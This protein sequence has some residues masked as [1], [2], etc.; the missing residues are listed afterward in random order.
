MQYIGPQTCNH[1]Q[2]RGGSRS[3]RLRVHR[4]RRA[5]RVRSMREPHTLRRAHR[6]RY[7]L[8]ETS[9]RSRPVASILEITVCHVRQPWLSTS[10]NNNNDDDA[11]TQGARIV[12]EG[13][14]TFS[15]DFG[16]GVVR[17]A[18]KTERLGA[19]SSCCLK[20]GY[21]MLQVSRWFSE[22]EDLHEGS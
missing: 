19:E 9:T 10:S 2:K 4:E 20:C 11:S 13:V 17:A 12:L 18:P 14:L 22:P 8:F 6:A 5:K 3:G 15:P 1:V 7:V 16:V 21:L